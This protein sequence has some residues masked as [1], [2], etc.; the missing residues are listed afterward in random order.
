MPA[1][2]ITGVGSVGME[3]IGWFFMAKLFLSP[4]VHTLWERSVYISIMHFF[5]RRLLSTVQIHVSELGQA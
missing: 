2:Y 5:D 1:V 3:L 4:E